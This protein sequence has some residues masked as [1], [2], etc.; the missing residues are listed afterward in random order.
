MLRNSTQ[1]LVV[2]NLK[3]ITNGVDF[4]SAQVYSK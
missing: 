4:P 2:K 1:N 3:N